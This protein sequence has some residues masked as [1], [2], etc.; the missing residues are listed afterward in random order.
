[1]T[2]DQ[3]TEIEPKLELIKKMAKENPTQE[4]QIRIMLGRYVG[5]WCNNIQLSTNQ[6]YD[7]ACA[8][9]FQ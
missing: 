7:T 2:W 3:M 8:E 1:M 4:N 9:I 5:W 6:C